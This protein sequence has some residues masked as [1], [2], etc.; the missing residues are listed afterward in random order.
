MKYLAFLILMSAPMLAISQTFNV[1]TKGATVD[2]NYVSE[3]TKGTLGDV[4]A[5][6]KIDTK[7]LGSATVSGSVDVST[8]STGNNLR[9]KHLK[10]K[11]FFDAK[12]YPTMKF[13]SSSVYQEG[14]DFF[15]KGK[16]TIKDV[17][18]E[19]AFKIINQE[20]KLL[21]KTTIYAADY[22]VAIKKDREKSK[23]DIVVTIPASK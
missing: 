14:D 2:F 5:T 15:A 3:K 4:A 20:D 17:T 8:L 9:D 22:G 13:A 16:L 21:F 12:T 10:S 18:K 6:L 7:K 23:V 19:V 11:D 1:N